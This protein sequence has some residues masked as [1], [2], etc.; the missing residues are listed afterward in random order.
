MFHACVAST[1]GLLSFA[2]IDS[3]TS[4]IEDEVL[5]SGLMTVNSFALFGASFNIGGLV[6]AVF[7]GVLSEWL[8]VKTILVITSQFVAFGAV[9]L[10]WAHDPVSMVTG[11]F[12]IG[13]FSA[14]CMTCVP[15]YNIDVSS[16]SSW[17]LYG[18]ILAMAV[19]VGILSSYLLGI[20]L[21]NRWL[22]VIY[23]TMVVFMI[24]NIAFL[25]ESPKWLTEKGW[26]ESAERAREYFY[27]LPEEET[28][29]ENGEND[30]STPLT[31]STVSQGK[32]PHDTFCQKI[33]SYLV[34]PVIRPLLVCGSIEVFKSFSCRDFM[35]SYSAH[36]LGDAV[37][38]NPRVAA[39]FYPISLLLGSIVF[40]ILIQKVRRWKILLFVTT[41][42]QA[43]AT[44][45]LAVTFY[46]AE[47]EYHCTTLKHLTTRCD[48]IQISVI[49][50][51][52]IYGF[53]YCIGWGSIIWWLYAKLLSKHY[54]SVSTGILALI[55]Y[56]TCI[57]NQIVGP[58]IAEYLGD[59]VVFVVYSVIAYTALVCQF[60]Y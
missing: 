34:W 20:W 49:A 60:F 48:Y 46:L 5:N 41:F 29:K 47:H 28:T 9:L 19:R 1:I 16:K 42:A 13:I 10:V 18:G 25:P 43:L 56:V 11:R 51:V 4:P 14:V 26:K 6:A 15:V 54:L 12:L 30:E 22:V 57:T 45:L 23:L 55:Y 53:F 58:I 59:Y 39:F 2:Y 35:F 38:I 33:S 40:L 8:G 24:L 7:T 36:T 52:C 31:A 27:D 50:L 17:E 44:T 37:R 3:Y 32:E 21:G